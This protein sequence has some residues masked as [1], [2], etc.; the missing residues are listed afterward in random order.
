MLCVCKQALGLSGT[1]WGGR[2]SV[3]K[4]HVLLLLPICKAGS[5]LLFGE[6]NLAD[7]S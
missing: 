7:S 2:V 6:I 4:D 1:P 5:E 3:P